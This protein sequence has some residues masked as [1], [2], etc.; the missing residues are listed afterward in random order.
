MKEIRPSIRS[1]EIVEV[2]LALIYGDFPP[3]F[4]A[5]QVLHKL[6]RTQSKTALRVLG[7]A[8]LLYRA[9]ASLDS[10]EDFGASLDLQ[11]MAK[12]RLIQVS[13]FWMH[14]QAIACG[15]ESCIRWQA[16]IEGMREL[17]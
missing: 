15:C 9:A 2:C 3:A 5:E 8:R 6:M 17:R 10:I 11:C 12:D 4:C 14:Y 13:G 7:A 16:K 1:S